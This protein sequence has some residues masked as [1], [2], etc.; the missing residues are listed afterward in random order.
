MENTQKRAPV[1]TFTAGDQSGVAEIHAVSGGTAATGTGG[2]GGTTTTATNVVKISVGAAAVNTVTLR[3]TPST[4]SPSGSSVSLVATVVGDSG[5]GLPGIP[6][7]FNSDQGA[8]SPQIAVTDGF[9]VAVS[10]TG[11][12]FICNARKMGR[13]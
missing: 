13:G 10:I 9:G 11:R 3:A 6:V 5:N 4:V 8:I 1:A 12:S 7:T 2:T